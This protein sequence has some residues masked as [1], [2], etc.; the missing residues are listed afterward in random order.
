MRYVGN[1]SFTMDF[2][3]VIATFESDGFL[4]VVFDGGDIV[5]FKMT[6]QQVKDVIKFHKEYLLSLEK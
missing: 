5:G 2:S 1:E 4:K 6:N 3:K